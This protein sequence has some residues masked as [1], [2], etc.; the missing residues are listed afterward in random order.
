MVAFQ[1]NKVAYLE[2]AKN[3]EKVMYSKQRYDLHKDGSKENSR[4]QSSTREQESKRMMEDQY[5]ASMEMVKSP[6]KDKS[7][8]IMKEET[9]NRL[10]AIQGR[11]VREKDKEKVEFS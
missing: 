9:M 6:L 10:Q 5:R 1:V 4:N 11:K 3:Q 2:R 7:S 8:G